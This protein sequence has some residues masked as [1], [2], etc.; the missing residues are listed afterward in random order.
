MGLLTAGYDH[1]RPT[2]AAVAVVAAMAIAISVLY[3]QPAA[4][5]P[6]KQAVAVSRSV[7]PNASLKGDPVHI[8]GRISRSPQGQR[9]MLQRY[10][11]GRWV[12]VR[13]T[14]L[15]PRHRYQFR[16]V[17]PAGR[18][19]YRVASPPDRIRLAGL[20]RPFAL[21][22]QPCRSMARPT[23]SNAVWFSRP[24]Q[25]TSQIA[26]GLGRLF[27]SA[28]KGATVNIA[29]YFI[30]KA[31]RRDGDVSAILRPLERMA[32][33]RGLT[34]RVLLEGKTYRRGSPLR[35]TLRRLRRFASVTLCDWG[36]RSKRPTPKNGGIAA[37]I[38]HHKFVTISDMRWRAG[39]DPVVVSSSANL[40]GSQL[41][42]WQSAVMAYDDQALFRDF[43]IQWNMMRTCDKSCM[44]WPARMADLGI[45]P[46]TN[47]LA[48]VNG[49]WY[50][51]VPVERQGDA[52]RG[53]GVVFSPYGGADPM[54]DALNQYTCTPEHNIVRVAHM[55]VTSARQSVLN[56]LAALQASGCD[57]RVVFSVPGSEL[58][59]DG[60]SRARAAGLPVTCVPKMH[61]KLILVDAVRTDT[62][63][64]ERA[65]WAGSQSL[66]GNA[67]S[68]N[69]EAM[70][71]L[72]VDQASGAAAAGNESVFRRYRGYWS[73]MSRR[74]AP[75]T[76]KQR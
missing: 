32:R 11:A 72:S 47:S 7:T 60:V 22:V 35:P 69:E 33:L 75:C 73:D 2:R 9:V 71:R 46:E 63:S 70:L 13:R 67:L 61:D 42:L 57:V 64:P 3:L 68:R 66:G 44:S 54:S 76:L 20:S 23:H 26:R 51:E 29:M 39:A 1:V 14:R 52:D 4:A 74:S 41:A 25:R 36:C 59:L 55:F 28:A 43:A 45:A 16:L 12:T 62:D 34:V 24:S 48:K 58:A 17:P 15:G 19:R 18:L 30:R 21:N 10:H 8:T 38:M 27:C 37:G 65:L 31:S 50:D 6:R 5:A 49:V 40:S 56:A 53:S